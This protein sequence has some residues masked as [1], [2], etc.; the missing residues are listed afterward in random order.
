MRLLTAMVHGCVP[1]VIQVRAACLPGAPACL[2]SLLPG[3]SCTCHW[4]CQPAVTH[5]L[6]LLIFLLLSQEHVFQ[7]FEDLLPYELFSLRL[8]N[9]DLPTIRETLR[10][11]DDAQYRELLSNVLRYR[12][13][14]LWQTEFGG[15]AF[16]Y[17]IATLRRRFLNLKS[18][19]Y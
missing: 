2:G 19:Y 7:P 15:R 3:C 4:L 6:P 13:A 16:D 9:D 1:V 12:H 18:L 17:T 8:D 10:G 5:S 14:F 11:I